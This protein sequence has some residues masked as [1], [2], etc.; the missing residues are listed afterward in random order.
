VP[1]PITDDER[2]RRL[3]TL[4]AYRGNDP[5]MLARRKR[6]VE[7][8]SRGRA[9]RELLRLRAEQR[10]RP[11]RPGDR[12]C[13]HVFSLPPDELMAEYRRKVGPLPWEAETS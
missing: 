5:E 8:L 11:I 12:E 13:Q 2:L 4:L 6:V 1:P 9:R 3:H 7:L 10:G